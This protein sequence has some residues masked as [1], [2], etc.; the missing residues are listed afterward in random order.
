M[1]FCTAYV[2]LL[3]QSGNY[4]LPSFQISA[5]SFHSPRTFSRTT[6]YFPEISFGVGSLVIKAKRPGLTCCVGAQS[7]DVEGS[8]F[9]IAH[10]LRQA[11]PHCAD[12]SPAF[13]HRGAGRKCD[14]VNGVELG[15]P[16]K[17]A[18]AK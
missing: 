7:L 14:R 12:R 15:N 10:M 3:T 13:H 9:R 1:P 18:F 8:D 4:Y 6:R 11:F 2:F 16:F 17:I 5:A